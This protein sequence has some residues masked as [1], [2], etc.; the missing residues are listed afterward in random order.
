MG[1]VQEVE[2][3]GDYAEYRLR[4]TVPVHEEYNLKRYMLRIKH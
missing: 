3:L 2:I 1:V 4:H